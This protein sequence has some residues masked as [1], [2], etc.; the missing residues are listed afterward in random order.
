MK[1]LVTGK[2]GSGKTTLLNSLGLQNIHFADDY[3]KEVMYKKDSGFYKDVVKEFGDVIN[4]EGLD[5]EKLGTIV[6]NDKEKMDRLNQLVV[7]YIRE[8]IS[9]LPGGAIVEMAVYINMED[10]YKDLFTKV[11]LI[12]RDDNNIDDK[13]KYLEI[14]SQPIG[15]NK[16]KYTHIIKNDGHIGDATIELK[17]L[18]T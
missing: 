2:S 3:V 5:S 11:I 16:I 13:F 8:W 9:S 15:D 7:P 18:L 6:F 10:A 12:E 17:S 1:I 14:K 4:D